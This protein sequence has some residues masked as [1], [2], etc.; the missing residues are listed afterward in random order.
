MKKKLTHGRA[1]A[2]SILEEEEGVEA[3]P[4]RGSKQAG[5]VIILLLLAA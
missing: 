5:S 2:V 1:A 4:G 3:A